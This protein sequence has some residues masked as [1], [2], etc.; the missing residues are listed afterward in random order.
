VNTGNGPIT[1]TGLTVEISEATRWN[2]GACF[3]VNLI[4][5]TDDELTWEIEIPLEGTLENLWSAEV[6]E[7]LVHALVVHGLNWNETLAPA[8]NTTFGYCVSF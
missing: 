1:P 6:S 5:D 7:T 3:D 4:N 2:T 8:A